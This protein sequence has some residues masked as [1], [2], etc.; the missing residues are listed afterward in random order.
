[1]QLAERAAELVRGRQ[2]PGSIMLDKLP[3]RHPQAVMP[4]RPQGQQITR[5]NGQAP[6][7]QERPDGNFTSEPLLDVIVQLRGAACSSPRN[8]RSGF[9]MHQHIAARSHHDCVLAG[10]R[11]G[12]RDRSCRRQGTCGAGVLS[13][14]KHDADW[15]W[16]YDRKAPWTGY[17]IGGSSGG[18]LINVRC[19][20]WARRMGGDQL[21]SASRD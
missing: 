15:H 2:R 10:D 18:M 17:P 7:C 16:L 3:E 6:F 8:N 12:E 21:A 19:A 11:T 1:M 20:S 9:K 5:R 14:M 13:H 4:V